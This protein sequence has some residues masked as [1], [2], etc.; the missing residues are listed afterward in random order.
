MTP[1]NR[2]EGPGWTPARRTGPAV[3]TAVLA[4]LLAGL[5]G[6]PVALAASVP[7]APPPAPATPA[8]PPAPAAARQLV[9]ADA[10]AVLRAVRAAGAKAVI[11]NI[12]ATWCAPCREE[13]PQIVKLGRDLK[14]RGAALVL[15]SGDFDDSRDDALKFLADHGVDFTTYLKTGSDEAFIDGFAPEWSGVLPA[16]MVFDGA[17][18]LRHFREGRITYQQLRDLVLDVID[19][20]AHGPEKETKR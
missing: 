2:S 8:A 11:V 5:P 14:E 15:V 10:A 19:N 20:P 9:P 4:A 17:A 6:A 12:W 13:F 1:R 3:A 16:T 7:A 18:R